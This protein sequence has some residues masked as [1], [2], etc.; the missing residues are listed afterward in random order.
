MKETLLYKPNQKG[1]K[2]AMWEPVGTV[3]GAQDLEILQEHSSLRCV[4]WTQPVRA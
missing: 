4:H 2:I 1:Y 3:G